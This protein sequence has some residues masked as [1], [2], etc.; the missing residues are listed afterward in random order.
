MTESIADDGHDFC[1]RC[2]GKIREFRGKY[3][4]E[5]SLEF[6]NLLVALAELSSQFMDHRNQIMG[7]L[8]RMWRC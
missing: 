8:V 4:T 2:L 7:S 6:S 1:L 3:S 5:S